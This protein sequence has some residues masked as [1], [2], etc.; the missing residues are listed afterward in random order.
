[1]SRNFAGLFFGRILSKENAKN[2]FL[3]QKTI[4]ISQ[5]FNKINYWEINR[6]YLNN[7]C[8]NYIYF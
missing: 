1:M 6:N 5:G 3:I 7:N 4:F 2:D 8:L